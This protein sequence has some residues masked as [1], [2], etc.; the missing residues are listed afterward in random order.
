MDLAALAPLV[1]VAQFFV[2]LPLAYTAGSF[3][4]TATYESE[5]E[6]LIVLFCAAVGLLMFLSGVFN[7]KWF[8]YYG[9]FGR[10]TR[11]L[12]PQVTRMLYILIGTFMV[13]LMTVGS[14]N[15]RSFSERLWPLNGP[16]IEGT[17][18][19]HLPQ[20]KTGNDRLRAPGARRPP[21]F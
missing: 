4:L 16:I 18:P 11:H 15:S 3:A 17:L 14:S 12:G 19:D 5:E 7:W 9:R 21:G 13:A 10:I 1:P 20:P 2:S 6:C 8:F